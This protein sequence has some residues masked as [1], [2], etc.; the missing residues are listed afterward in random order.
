MDQHW[1]WSDGCE[2][3]FKISHVFQWL[4]ILHKKVKLPD[5]WNYF[6]SLNRKQEHGGVGACIKRELCKKEMNFTTNSLIRDEKSIFEWSSSVMGEG[7]RTLE[8]Q[9][10]RKGHVHRYF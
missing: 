2:G 10:P 5:V 8:D 1:I 7:T 4:C 3:Q 6:E 9:L